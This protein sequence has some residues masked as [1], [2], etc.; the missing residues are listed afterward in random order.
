ME[1]VD[2]VPRHQME[3][4]SRTRLVEDA[5]AEASGAV[6][7]AA[8]DDMEEGAE[9]QVV[10]RAAVAKAGQNSRGEGG[11]RNHSLSRRNLPHHH[12]RP[13]RWC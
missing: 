9:V 6:F 1:A 2:N 7:A 13:A 8:E 4:R 5:V 3:A 10:A 11:R 12:W